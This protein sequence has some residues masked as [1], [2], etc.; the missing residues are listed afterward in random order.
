MKH[1]GASHPCKSN[2][3][4]G[5]IIDEVSMAMLKELPNRTLRGTH[6]IFFKP[7]T[8]HTSFT[9]FLANTMFTF[10]LIIF[11]CDNFFLFNFWL[12]MFLQKK[13]EFG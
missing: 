3:S 7:S 2:Y 8:F 9:L 1:I 6:L 12:N 4:Y 5:Y 13:K 10:I 11:F